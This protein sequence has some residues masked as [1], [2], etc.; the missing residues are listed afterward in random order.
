MIS[1]ITMFVVIVALGYGAYRFIKSRKEKK[2]AM[3][4]S[5][6]AGGGKSGGFI[7]TEKK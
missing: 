6:L 4:G 5:A 7:K 3:A 2:E 1:E